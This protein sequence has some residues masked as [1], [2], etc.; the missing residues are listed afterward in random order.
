MME[1]GRLTSEEVRRRGIE[2]LAKNLGPVD[3]IRFLQQ[4]SLGTGDYSRNRHEWL[5]KLTVS[6]IAKVAKRQG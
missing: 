6:E 2:V 1:N 3:T 4:F 5:D